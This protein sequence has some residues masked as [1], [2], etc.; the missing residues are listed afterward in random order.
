MVQ[1]ISLKL[2]N[3]VLVGGFLYRLLGSFDSKSVSS[4]VSWISASAAAV[5]YCR[6]RDLSR[7]NYW[8]LVLILW[9]VYSGLLSSVYVTFIII[10]RLGSKD[11]HPTPLAGAADIVNIISCALS[12]VLCSTA[13]FTSCSGS[14]RSNELERPLLPGGSRNDSG[15]FDS[16]GVWSKLT[17]QTLRS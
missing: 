13:I 10:R 1:A 16:A 14:H 6:K 8:P 3:V 4:A 11:F 9:W 12:L 5:Y 17:F 2:V 15:D 7:G